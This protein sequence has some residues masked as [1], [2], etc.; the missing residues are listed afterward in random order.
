MNEWVRRLQLACACLVAAVSISGANAQSPQYPSK[1][2]RLVVP[3]PPGGATDILARA[4]G[5]DLTRAWGQSVTIENR[6]GAGG[7]LGA[8]VVAKAPADG[9]TLVMGTVGTH[10][11]NASLYAKMPY[12]AVTDFAPVSLVASVPNVLVVHPSLP[13][14]SVRELIELARAKPGV[15]NFA[16]SGNGT[17]IHLSGELFKTMAGVQMT[18]IPYKGS[19]PALADLLGGQVSLMF[20][21]MPSVLPQIKA[22]KLR[23]LAVTSAKRS[24]ALPELPTIAEAGLAGYEASSWFGVL[25]PAG[26]P[27]DI[28]GKLSQTIAA[29]LHGSEMKERLSSQGAE[30]IG[31][32]PEQFAAHIQAEI[33]KWARV[34]KASGA[35]LD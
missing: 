18:H 35:K 33:A 9:Y 30:P 26:T 17:S 32:T 21:N 11:I 27:K 13:V 6:G 15:I 22:D 2:I 25:A 7:N 23:A 5:A 12:D 10:A 4:V 19:A 31:S 20:D 16:S 34:V 3:F 28:V 29:A 1:P 8:E 24:P 14:R